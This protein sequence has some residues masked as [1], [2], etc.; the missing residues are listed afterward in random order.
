MRAEEESK[1]NELLKIE[2]GKNSKSKFVDFEVIKQ[3]LDSLNPEQLTPGSFLEAYI[4]EIV[5]KETGFLPTETKQDLDTSSVQKQLQMKSYFDDM[6]SQLTSDKMVNF[7]AVL[8]QN[9]I[10]QNNSATFDEGLHSDVFS[11]MQ[12]LD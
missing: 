2:Q 6:F 10:T 1:R 12:D 4:D 11:I 7:E 3:Q 5:A 9:L 8:Q